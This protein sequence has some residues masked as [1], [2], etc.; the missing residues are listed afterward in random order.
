M[1]KI[2]SISIISFILV[3]IVSCGSNKESSIDVE[4]WNDITINDGKPIELI[5]DLNGLL[6]TTNTEPTEQ[7][8]TV[9]RSIQDI[10]DEF[11][12]MFPNVTI[13][14]AYSK[15]SVGDWAQWMTTQVASNDA[16]DIVM[17]HG[18]KYSDR[19]WYEDLTDVMNEPNIFIEKGERGSIHWKDMFPDYMWLSSMTTNA[20]GQ[21][22]AVPVMC[23][24]GSATAYYYNKEIFEELNLDVPTNWEEFKNVC[25]IINNAGYVAVGPW[26][27]NATANVDTWDIQFSLGPTYAN[28]I[29]DQWDYDDNNYMTQDEMLR[30]VYEGVF[31]GQGK[32][33]ENILSLYSEVKYKY[34][35]ILQT[36]AASTYYQPYWTSGQVAMME[37][38]LWRINEENVDVLRKFEYGMFPTPLADST[39]SKY[40]TD[41]IFG[42]GA[43][44]PPICES[45]NIVKEAS[46]Q[47]GEAHFEASKLFLMY[48]TTPRNI[49]RMVDEQ[50]GQ[51]IGAVYDT[52]VPLEVVDYIK[53]NFPRTPNCNWTTGVT[54]DTQTKMSRYFQYW[55]SDRFN[56]EKFFKNY[57]KELHQGCMDMIAAL[58]IDVSTWHDGYDPNFDYSTLNR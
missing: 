23:Y 34:N 2:L 22:C 20:K 31:Y 41:F 1:K 53:G 25:N 5:F 4:K 50:H 45:F 24:P 19:G 38:G 58:D 52:I 21:I 14:W 6:P 48:L 26:S 55:V 7:Q 17:M 29:K 18:S 43:Y 42:E 35:E 47:K 37:D 12:K 46:K 27:L 56:N 15:K 9:F 39:T 16:P 33:F 40:C 11:C 51:Y 54:V 3:S 32:N 8:P 44:N 28:K 10:A 30:A 57:D 49:N 13:N 36:G